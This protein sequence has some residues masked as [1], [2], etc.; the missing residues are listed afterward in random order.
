[1]RE[2]QQLFV[3]STRL[4][5]SFVQILLIQSS[6]AKKILFLGDDPF[7]LWQQIGASSEGGGSLVPPFLGRLCLHVVFR[8]AVSK[9]F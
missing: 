3:Y 1:M 9:F 6:N 2:Q 7:V 4:Q 5:R 8:D